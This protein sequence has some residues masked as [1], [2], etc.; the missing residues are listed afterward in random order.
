MRGMR[1]ANFIALL[2]TKKQHYER[3]T[4]AT[5][6]SVDGICDRH[7]KD[8]E[9]TFGNRMLQVTGMIL[10]IHVSAPQGSCS[11]LLRFYNKRLERFPADSE[12]PRPEEIA[13]RKDMGRLA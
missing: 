4:A 9:F 8:I 10:K 12:L 2:N 11:K 6:S 13:S 1:P 3:P 7:L 5:K